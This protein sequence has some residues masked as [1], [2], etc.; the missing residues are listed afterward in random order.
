[1]T[2]PTISPVSGT[3]RPAAVPALRLVRLHL[4][5]RRVT[6][7]LATVAACALTLHIALQWSWDTYGALQLPLILEVGCAAAIGITMGSPFGEPERATGRWLPLLRLGSAIAMTATAVAALALASIG[8]HLAGG[9]AEVV[10]NIAGLV[11][12]GLL[13]ALLLGGSLA[14]TGPVV[15]ML[16]GAYGLYTDW[17]PPT[18][19]SPWI[20]PAR[21]PHDLG[22]AL[23]AAAVFA[24]GIAAATWRGARESP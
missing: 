8:A 15:Y 11:G 23:C 5:S 18:L 7:A 6:A 9:I 17:H 24:A 4:A 14:W 20:W 1:M 16:V 12:I 3:M 2:A 10:R 13:C 21:P 22:A 19:T